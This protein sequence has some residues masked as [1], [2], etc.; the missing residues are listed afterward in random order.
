MYIRSSLSQLMK[1]SPKIE[2]GEGGG[3][4]LEQIAAERIAAISEATTAGHTAHESTG[5]SRQV[6]L[7]GVN[8]ES[9]HFAKASNFPDFKEAA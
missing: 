1:L 3:A 5:S 4:A 6:K 7:I 8:W 9:E 2:A